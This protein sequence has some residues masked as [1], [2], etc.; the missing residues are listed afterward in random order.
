MSYPKS[1]NEAKRHVYSW[2]KGKPVHNLDEV[3][4]RSEKIESNLAR[5]APHV[6]SEEP[7][8]IPGA[9]EWLIV[10]LGNDVEMEKIASFLRTYYGTEK[11]KLECTIEF[12]RWTLGRQGVL[13]ALVTNVG[14]TICG[15]V[16]ATIMNM[17][18]Y[19]KKERFGQ[20]LFL[21]AHPIYRKKKLAGVLIDEM[22]RRLNLMG[23]SQ[24]LFATK[25]CVPTPIAHI[26]IYYRPLNYK[27][28]IDLKYLSSD[29]DKSE[30]FGIEIDSTKYVPMKEEN[31]G[32]VLELYGKWMD[33]FNVYN[34][35]DE[36]EFRDLLLGPIVRS[37]V[38]E[39]L[40]GKIVDFL[41]FYE[42]NFVF[43]GKVVKVAHMF[44]YSANGIMAGDVIDNVVKL[45]KGLGFD[46]LLVPDV[47]TLGDALLTKEKAVDEDSEVEEYE[48]MYEHQCTKTTDRM[49]VN[50]FNWKCPPVRP[51]QMGVIPVYFP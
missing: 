1:I 46:L 34:R 28:L 19:D 16:G 8:K 45:A 41:S 9:M 4:A 11:I 26:R 35:Y 51:R 10:D 42:C 47:M 48:R 31:V 22:T 14:K 44:L 6:V 13:I 32:R 15:V 50:L 20:P 21:C 3:V 33:R 25:L 24:G 37:Y 40:N 23:V 30:Y 38:L 36:G 43:D 17:M 39:D 12:M 18:M 27:R 49:F 5:R 7:M 2:W 29:S